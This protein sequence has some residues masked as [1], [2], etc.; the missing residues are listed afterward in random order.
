MK[1]LYYGMSPF[2]PSGYG[3]CTKELVFRLRKWFEIDINSYYAFTNSELTI[4]TEYGKIKIMGNT[5]GNSLWDPKLPV[6]AMNYDVVVTHMDQWFIWSEWPK[7]KRPLIH[8]LV[9]DHDPVSPIIRKIVGMENVARIVPT[10]YWAKKQLLRD[11]KEHSDVIGEPIYHGVDP[12]IYTPEIRRKIPREILLKAMGFPEDCEFLVGAVVANV[13]IRELIPTMIEAFALFIKETNAKAYLYIHAYPYKWGP[14]A[15]DLVTVR[16]V[17][18]EHYGISKDL[19]RFKGEDLTEKQMAQVYNT[20][21][22]Q[23]MTI[24]GGSF[25]IPLIEAGAC[26]T[27]SI[28]TN[29]S[30]MP[31]VV[32]YGERGLLVEPTA[33]IWLQALSA[34]HAVVNAKDVAEAIRIYYEDKKLREKHGKKMREWILKNCTWDI[35]AEKWKKLL[36]EVENEIKSYEKAYFAGRDVDKREWDV[37]YSEIS[38]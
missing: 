12:N 27:P 18:C 32:G 17:I 6:R 5:L 25:E 26:E 24:M 34:K 1:I 29:F 9:M 35:V 21:D 4:E 15:Y 31:E 28:T 7:V 10:S 20:I 33:Y 36:E 30:G 38:P 37:I 13:G 8:W 11:C 22:V 16:D 2:V 14:A 23:L 3:K 19:I